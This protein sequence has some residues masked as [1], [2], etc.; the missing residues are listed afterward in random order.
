MIKIIFKGLALGIGNL[1][2]NASAFHKYKIPFYRWAGLKIGDNTTLV[3]PINVPIDGQGEVNIGDNTYVNALT[4]FGPN[5][6][7]V[8]IG[9]QCLIGPN[10]SFETGGHSLI[11]DKEQGRGHSSKKILIKEKV[12]I[13]A[14]VVVLQGVTVGSRSVIAAGAVV[15][16]DIPPDSLWGGVPAKEIK[17]I[18]Y[19]S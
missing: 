18:E 3:G 14:N 2:P 6:S 19:D 17:K 7:S 13:G 15:I 16:C 4:R 8:I 1:I 9:N 11:F 10:V 5:G 12:W